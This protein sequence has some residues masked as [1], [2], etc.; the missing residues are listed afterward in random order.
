MRA[1]FLILLLS[2]A[3][4]QVE[5]P[6]SPLTAEEQASRAAAE[7]A[8]KLRRSWGVGWGFDAVSGEKNDLNS[9]TSQIINL[10]ELQKLTDGF[11]G[12]YTEA[13]GS[14]SYQTTV[15]G[16]SLAEYVHNVFV[17][18]K[19][20]AEILMYEG[21]YR[22][23]L[24][25]WESVRE[26]S[27]FITAQHIERR[28]VRTID[29]ESVAVAAQDNPQILTKSFIDAVEQLGVQVDGNNLEAIHEFLMCWGTHVVSQA[30]L[31][32]S[33]TLDVAVDEKAVNTHQADEKLTQNAI[34]LLFKKMSEQG[35]DYNFEQV[36]KSAK[37]NFAVRGGNV[38]LTNEAVLNPSLDNAKLTPGMFD[39]WAQSV[40]ID[41][42]ELVDM[43]VFPIWELIIDASLSSAV[44]AYVLDNAAQ[45]ADL[46]GGNNYTNTSISLA[47]LSTVQCKIGGV[48]KT[49]NNPA[50]IDVVAGGRYVA[51]II[52][53]VIPPRIEPVWVVYPI[54]N[55]RI[56]ITNGLFIENGKAYRVAWRY[57]EFEVTE[58]GDT[59]S[60]TV[61]LNNGMPEVSRNG[62]LDYIEGKFIFGCEVPGGITTGGAFSNAAA[63]GYRKSGGNFYLQNT[64]DYTAPGLPGWHYVAG[65]GMVR[66]DDYEYYL[67][68]AEKSPL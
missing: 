61:W 22:S 17:D 66:D 13:Y 56:D 25:I 6:F 24:S 5:E 47:N 28:G 32:G 68:L 10:E 42:A 9:A 1:L 46:F 49:F 64:T 35:E 43:E 19:A 31:G 52:H 30:A 62:A 41:N 11:E 40:T 3:A 12:L 4:C 18:T 36:V 59:S 16:H 44:E 8:E 23:K 15:A 21:S 55:R 33:L 54:Y 29:M 57:G 58:L 60:T 65:Q 26:R 67:N 38:S 53:E 2:L 34:A 37:C 63:V 48:T 20:S 14:E 51:S 45:L 50:A 27:K 7:R 39:G